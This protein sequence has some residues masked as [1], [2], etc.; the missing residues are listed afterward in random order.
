MWLSDRTVSHGTIETW[1]R[2]AL[3]LLSS[4]ERELWVLVVVALLADVYLTQ[5]GLQAGLREGNPVAR[6]LI[7]TF[8]IG[9]LAVFKFAVVGFAGVLRELVPARQAP[10]IPLGLAIPW[11]VAAC[12]NATLLLGQ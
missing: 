10:T 5:T 8:G 12:I 9:A 3:D 2:R 11:V 6:H 4:V 1:G 7:E